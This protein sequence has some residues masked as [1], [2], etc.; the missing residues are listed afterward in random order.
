[1][2][3]EPAAPETPDAVQVHDG[4]WAC[5]NCSRR[6]DEEYCPRCG[7]QRRREGDLSVRHVWRQVIHETFDVDGRILGSIKLLLTRPG[8]LTLDFLEGRRVRHVHPLK[9]FLVM[10]AIYF[11][12]S[13]G[14]MVRIGWSDAPSSPSE[15]VTATQLL[16][17]PSPR[18]EQL[19][20]GKAESQNLSYEAFKLKVDGQLELLFKAAFTAG[21]VANGFGLALLFRGRRPYLAEHMV[22]ALHV[23]CFAM[24]VTVAVQ[25]VQRLFGLGPTRLGGLIAVAVVLYFV[26]AARRVYGVH[27]RRLVVAGVLMMFTGVSVL[28]TA[29][30]LYLWRLLF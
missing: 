10:S 5:P 22:M 2:S 11:L 28:V 6:S 29:I 14:P 12:L 27:G 15:G 21:V 4:S 20:R 16:G 26:A 9:L 17:R 1:V 13:G 24:V 25:Q 18:V 19:L 3:A 23:S 30:A 8:Q 7:Q